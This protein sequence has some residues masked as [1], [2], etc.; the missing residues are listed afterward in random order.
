VISIAS[1][2][3]TVAVLVSGR[4]GNQYAER[5]SCSISANAAVKSYLASEKTPR[6]PVAVATALSASH[7]LRHTC[8]RHTNR[9]D[10]RLRLKRAIDRIAAQTTLVDP[11]RQLKE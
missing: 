8:C 3:G 1:G 6:P 7:P 4:I 11:A 2:V 10:D 5:S 9:V